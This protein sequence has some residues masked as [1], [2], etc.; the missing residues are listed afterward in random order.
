MQANAPANPLH[1]QDPASFLR[2][3][4]VLKIAAVLLL[5]TTEVGSR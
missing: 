3:E 4:S 1:D 2:H 5:K